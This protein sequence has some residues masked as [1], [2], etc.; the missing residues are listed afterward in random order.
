MIA[1]A[2]V[3]IFTELAESM[4]TKVSPAFFKMISAGRVTTQQ[5]TKAF[6]KMTSEGGKFYK[7][8]E[9]ASRTTTGMWSTL[10]DNISLTAAE[11]GGVLAP[12]IKDLILR[13]TGIAQRMRAWVKANRELINTKF[14]EY[15]EV[16]KEALKS[17]AAGFRW[18]RTHKDT[19]LKVAKTVAILVIGLKALAAVMAV[20]N[21]AMMANPFGLVIMG[22]TALVAALASAVVWWDEFKNAAARAAALVVAEF[23]SA[24]NKIM[25]LVDKVLAAPAAV[26]GLWRSAAGS[27]GSLFAG[28]DE[29]VPVAQRPQVVSPE[30]RAAGLAQERRSTNTTEVTIRDETNRAEVTRGRLGTGVSLIPSGVF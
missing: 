28:P 23:T 24:V 6:E 5:L 21:L 11:L 4:G 14:L 7:G 25:A 15:I 8:M 13:A 18:L 12:T 19:V 16:V 29:A 17:L 22:V 10:K 9:I 2:G 26:A 3:P 27:I 1:E 30:E 20:V